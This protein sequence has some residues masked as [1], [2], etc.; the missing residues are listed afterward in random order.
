MG[1]GHYV[2]R[3]SR[4]MRGGL[5]WDHSRHRMGRNAMSHDHVYYCPQCG[6]QVKDVRDCEC[7]SPGMTSG[8]LCP[9]CR[10]QRDYER[11]Q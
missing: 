5:V 10:E 1:N 8:G 6:Y 11:Y 7:M 4:P 2:G 9:P 3:D